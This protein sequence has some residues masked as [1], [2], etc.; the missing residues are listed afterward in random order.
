M[1]VAAPRQAPM[2]SRNR[3][4]DV[5]QLDQIADALRRKDAEQRRTEPL[6]WRWLTDSERSKWRELAMVAALHFSKAD[7][8]SAA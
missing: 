6:D 1:L 4:A 5:N 8:G 3:M 2:D 7:T